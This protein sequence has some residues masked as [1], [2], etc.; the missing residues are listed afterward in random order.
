[1]TAVSLDAHPDSFDMSSSIKNLCVHMPCNPTHG[2]LVD[3]NLVTMVANSVDHH[4]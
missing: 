4:G 3:V 2:N 1:M